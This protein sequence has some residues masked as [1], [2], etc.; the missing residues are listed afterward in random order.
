MP[1]RSQQTLDGNEAVARV[2][3]LA[4]EVIA[5]YPITPAS[6]MGEPAD[7]WAADAERVI[8]VMGSGAETAH[9]TVEHL[10]GGGERVGLVKIRLYLPFAAAV[11]PGQV[12]GGTDRR[13]PGRGPGPQ[14]AH[15][16]PHG[17]RDAFRHTGAEPPRGGRGPVRGHY[18]DLAQGKPDAAD[19]SN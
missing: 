17:G 4:N 5:I 11:R 13:R 6:T 18:R 12:P 8:V 3:Y 10:D 14:P 15:R 1:P 19:K 16:R 9:E 7:D 2:A